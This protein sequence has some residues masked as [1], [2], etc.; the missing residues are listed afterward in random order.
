MFKRQQGLAPVITTANRN[1]GC[2]NK[3][4]MCHPVLWWLAILR[5]SRNRYK[6]NKCFY[7]HG[8][9]FE[10]YDIKE[11]GEDQFVRRIIT[12]LIPIYA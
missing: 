4:R 6:Q 12:P 8:L 5:K 10:D 1:P 3:K 9:S 11:I 7:K 2:G